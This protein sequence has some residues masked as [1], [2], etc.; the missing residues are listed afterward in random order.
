MTPEK[1]LNTFSKL[2]YE[3]CRQT[4]DHIFPLELHSLLQKL[5]LGILRANRAL[6]DEIT[7]FTHDTIEVHITPAIHEGTFVYPRRTELSQIQYRIS[8]FRV[9]VRLGLQL[10]SHSSMSK[11]DLRST[12]APPGTTMEYQIKAWQTPADAGQTA[13]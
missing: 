12:T 4:W 10:R 13:K 9:Y 2:P 6:H 8:W 3:F 1:T 11:S 5:Q 7:N